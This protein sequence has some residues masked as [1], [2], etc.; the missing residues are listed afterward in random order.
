MTIPVLLQ[1]VL[2]T[3]RRGNVLQEA[4]SAAPARELPD[5]RA[6][7]VAFADGFQAAEPEEQSR[8]IEWTRSPGHLLLLVPP[9]AAAPCARPVSWRAER[10]D[11]V[12]RGGEGIAKVLAPEVAYRLT[13]NLQTP[14]VPG[15]TWSDLSVCVGSYRLHPAAGLFAV[16]CLPLWS[17]AVLDV[18][19]EV[20]AW[21]ACLLDLSG[22]VRVAQAPQPAALQPDHYGLLVFLLSQAFENEEQALAGLRSSSIFRFSAERGRSLLKELR[23]R[24]L[25]V[26]AALTT[27]AHEVVMQSPYAAYVSAVR[28]VSR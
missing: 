12:P 16:T 20:E 11:T 5:G 25:V 23:D 10:I 19:R 9:F 13:G 22:D 15:A 2:A 7:V 14:A 4:L 8:L 18:P 28:E 24:G 26:G 1:G 17:L 3:H 27:E 21:L 6:I